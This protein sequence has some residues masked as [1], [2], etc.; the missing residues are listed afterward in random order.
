VSATQA[1]AS[2]RNVLPAVAVLSL[3]AGLIHLWV[4]PEHLEECWGYGAF[5]LV[6]AVAQVVYAPLLLLLLALI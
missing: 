5:F 6:A 3:I 4:M 1:T 2:Q